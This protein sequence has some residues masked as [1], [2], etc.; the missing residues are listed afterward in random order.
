MSLL[1]ANC[2]DSITINNSNVRVKGKKQDVYMKSDNPFSKSINGKSD[3]TK[4]ND[5]IDYYLRNNRIKSIDD[6]YFGS[7]KIVKRLESSSG[8]VL[9]IDHIDDFDTIRRI[10]GKYNQDRY[11]FTLNG[12]DD[13]NKILIRA[14][15]NCSSYTKNGRTIIYSMVFNRDGSEEKLVPFEKVFL[16]DL[17]EMIGK[18]EELHIVDMY[19]TGFTDNKTVCGLLVVGGGQIIEIDNMYASRII[20]SNEFL[21]REA[22]EII[23]EHNKR[24]K[25]EKEKYGDYTK[26]QLKMKGF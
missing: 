21:K 7:K 10:Q 14:S 9:E 16:K 23:N 1:D 6:N 11:D 24:V 5:I 18:N 25:E 12:L 13:S 19:Y 2:Y 8:K 3:L 15:K 22:F 20:R 26:L 17:I 4:K